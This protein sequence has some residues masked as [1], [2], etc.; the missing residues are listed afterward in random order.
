MFVL[1]A[2]PRLN[3]ETKI[4]RLRSPLN[5][6]KKRSLYLL[7]FVIWLI[8]TF[9]P[10]YWH[11]C[12]SIKYANICLRNCCKLNPWL[13]QYIFKTTCRL[14][15]HPALYFQCVLKPK[16]DLHVMNFFRLLPLFYLSSSS[17]K[18][19]FVHL[20]SDAFMFDFYTSNML[21]INWFNKYSF[22]FFRINRSI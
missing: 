18:E 3:A 17:Y 21:V 9:N 14:F 16:W 13:P 11:V 22:L 20:I 4:E 2:P 8:S 10:W 12:P 1:N 7:Q 5:K 15:A 19:C 6:N